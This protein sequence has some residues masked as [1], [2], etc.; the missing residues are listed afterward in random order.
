MK[1]ALRAV[2]AFLIGA[3]LCSGRQVADAA[4]FP[5]PNGDLTALKNAIKAANTNGEDDTIELATNGYYSL[6]IVDNGENGL[7]PILSDNNSK[8]TIHGNGATIQRSD[9]EAKIFRIF[10]VLSYIPNCRWSI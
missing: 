5:V 2:L 3:L 1:R 10:Y 6:T 4:V 7:P 9:K 8:L